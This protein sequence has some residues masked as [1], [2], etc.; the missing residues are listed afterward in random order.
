[1][2]CKSCG[3]KIYYENGIYKCDSCGTVSSIETY[4]EEVEVY[5]GYVE[6][7]ENG[8]RSQSS[9][10]VQKIYEHLEKQGIS[11]F[12]QRISLDNLSVDEA[13]RY[14]QIAY[15]KAKL[16]LICASSVDE[17]KSVIEN[18][19]ESIF[20]KK[21]IP[22]CFSSTA[23]ILPAKL[24]SYQAILSN[25]LG[26]ISD[27]EKNVCHILRKNTDNDFNLVVKRQLEKKKRR[28]L[29]ISACSLFVIF[30]VIIY[31]VFGTPYVL[32]S[33]KYSY[34]QALIEKGN[35]LEAVSLLREIQDYKDATDII[36]DVYNKYD[37]YY[38]DESK[39]LCLM[40][41][42]DKN[43]I[44]EIQL[45]K[46][47]DKG[48]IVFNASSQIKD[49]S[50]EFWYVDSLKNNGSGL[51]NLCD[52]G[53]LVNIN[54]EGNNGFGIFE[55]K[56]VFSNRSDAPLPITMSKKFLLEILNNNYSEEKI[57]SC[58]FE[59]QAKEYD[60]YEITNNDINLY[61]T[62]LNH[63]QIGK[64]LAD[65]E[66]GMG[67]TATVTTTSSLQTYAASAQA[68]LLLPNNIGTTT[69][70]F[71]K[72]DVMYVPFAK[73]IA[74]MGDIGAAIAPLFDDVDVKTQ[75]EANTNVFVA[76]KTS[77]GDYYWY[78]L[79]ERVAGRYNE[80]LISLPKMFFEDNNSM[81]M[82]IVENYPD[83]RGYITSDSPGNY[84]VYSFSKEDFSCELIE[85][86]EFDS[87]EDFEK[88][89][90]IINKYIA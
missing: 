79:C 32:D 24:N 58:G 85:K 7:D 87:D 22:V 63:K 33:K 69:S 5:I 8:R 66:L 16:L 12:Y 15:N 44:A 26:Y 78:K 27:I 77:L 29:L 64:E 80:D 73:V 60:C 38:T 71:I 68:E 90:E 25:Q 23:D 20:Y 54:S 4:F 83:S 31:F 82:Y 9:V 70:A 35:Y 48:N 3:G 67:T 13:K 72:N 62:N 51:I 28:N 39:T 86:V 21:L 55:H 2:I 88:L 76:T 89:K 11:T 50:I 43:Y 81:Y 36:N 65:D 42:I 14:S 47:T 46:V 18:Y 45:T 41:N 52:N 57:T 30:A 6:L 84:Q 53:I 34:A 75:I 10:N 61:M 74:H 1:M 49:N 19:G 40:L 37:G 59:I 56:F 17:F